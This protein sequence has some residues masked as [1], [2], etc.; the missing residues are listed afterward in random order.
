MRDCFVDCN[1]DA[2]KLDAAMEKYFTEKGVGS[3]DNYTVVK[4]DLSVCGNC[5]GTMDLRQETGTH[6][7]KNHPARYLYCEGC[8]KAYAV[9]SRGEL[10]AHEHSCPICRFQV[11]IVRNMETNK[12]H[13]VCPYCF[14][15]GPL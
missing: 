5:H 12:D 8:K 15:C 13:T 9:P 7:N 11:L 14:R 2:H 10:L 4:A 1:R 3:L 6:A